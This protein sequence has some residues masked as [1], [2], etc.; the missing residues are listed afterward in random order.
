MK[1]AVIGTGSV[2]SCLGGQLLKAGHSIKYGSR[3]PSSENMA[4]LIQKQPGTS[5]AAIADAVDWGEAIIV[6]VKMPPEDAGIQA[7]AASLGPGAKGKV[8]LDT[9]NATTPFPECELRW[10][11]ATSG[12]EVLAAALP[13]SFV[14]KAWNTTGVEHMHA[15]DGSA[16]NGQQLAMLYAG[17]PEKKDVAEELVRA[18]GFEPAYVGPIRYARNLEAI[19]E[20]WIHLSMK[21]MG[22]TD[23]D[24]GKNFHFQAIRKV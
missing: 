19:A 7:F 8:V 5:G 20:L 16:I 22:Q 4:A 2:G 24:W 17:A 9:T 1:V 3:N 10:Q 23:E 15:P 11:Q 6:A 13:D 18:S 12:G 21:V 14:F